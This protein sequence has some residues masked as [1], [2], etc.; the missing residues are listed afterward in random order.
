MGFNKSELSVND[1]GSGGSWKCPRRSL[2]RSVL[3]KGKD[4]VAVMH[5]SLCL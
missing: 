4:G 1:P 2:C 3:D 5:L